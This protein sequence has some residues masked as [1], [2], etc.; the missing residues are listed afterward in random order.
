MTDFSTQFAAISDKVSQCEEAIR[1]INDDNGLNAE[2]AFDHS[3]ELK[4]DILALLNRSEEMEV[5]D[6]LKFSDLAGKVVA[7]NNRVSKKLKEVS[8][9]IQHM[10]RNVKG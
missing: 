9:R 2:R 8:S 3:N 1:N 6:R 7:C 10:A 5:E 4:R